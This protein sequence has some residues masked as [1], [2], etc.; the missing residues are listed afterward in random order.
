[1]VYRKPKKSVS[2]QTIALIIL[3]LLLRILL[4][5]IVFLFLLDALTPW[6]E[7]AV[8]TEWMGSLLFALL[9]TLASV[10]SLF[11]YNKIGRLLLLLLQ[12]K[13]GA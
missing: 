10:L 11:I 9:F 13:G 5:F 12:S 6:F 2:W 3:T 1:M 4:F 7:V 8:H